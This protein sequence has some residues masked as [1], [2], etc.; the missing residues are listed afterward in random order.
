MNEKE[1]ILQAVLETRN[2]YKRQ[3]SKL[4]QDLYLETYSYS[5]GRLMKDGEVK[6]KSKLHKIIRLRNKIKE[7][8]I[9]YEQYNSLYIKLNGE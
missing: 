7:K 9:K 8:N 6:C 2:K 1:L 5:L 3:I 4:E